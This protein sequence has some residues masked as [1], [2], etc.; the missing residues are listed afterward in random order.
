MLT[1]PSHDIDFKEVCKRNS[2]QSVSFKGL[3]IN[4]DETSRICNKIKKASQIPE[5]ENG[6]L[7]IALSPI[8]FINTDI[9]AAI[10]RL[11]ANIAKYK[12]L[13][14]I[15]LFSKIVAHKKATKK[16]YGKGHFFLRKKIDNLCR[17]TLFI[18][19]NNCEINLSKATL[20]KIHEALS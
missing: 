5:G 1:P 20:K 2:I 16:D 17:E 8:Y 11:E 18:C 7:F 10:T 6:L 4:E 13:L 12:N 19:N 3:P 15:I 14:G 9:N